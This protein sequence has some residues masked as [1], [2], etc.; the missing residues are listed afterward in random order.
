MAKNSNAM[1][2]LS[3]ICYFEIGERKQD[4]FLEGGLDGGGLFKEALSQNFQ[5][6]TI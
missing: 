5:Y 2:Q 3:A 4:Y 6:Y 1:V